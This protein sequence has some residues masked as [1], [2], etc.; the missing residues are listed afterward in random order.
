MRFFPSP[1]REPRVASGSGSF[2]VRDPS[3][4][5][6]H[7]YKIWQWISR[8]FLNLMMP[9]HG[10]GA[11]RSGIWNL[12]SKRKNIHRQCRWCF[13]QCEEIINSLAMF[14]DKEIPIVVVQ[15]LSHVWLFVTPWTA[16]HQA[17][18]SFTISQSLLKLMSI[19]WMV[20]SNH[21]ILC[22]PL[23]FLPSILPRIGRYWVKESG[24]SNQKHYRY[25]GISQKF[26]TSFSF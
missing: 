13:T 4:S 20:P 15:S 19:E 2:R 25:S 21:P 3:E 1:S 18:L 22:C 11:I 23:L 5:H 8:E 26:S 12:D 14:S 6:I 10:F 7:E 9:L 17:S 24:E 16:A